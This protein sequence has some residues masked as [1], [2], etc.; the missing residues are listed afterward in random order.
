MQ[1]RRTQKDEDA[2]KAFISTISETDLGCFVEQV[3]MI[4]A[5]LQVHHDVQ[6]GRVVR[7]PARVQALE[8]PGQDVAI[9][10]PLHRGQVDANN[11][12][13]LRDE[14]LRSRT[15]MS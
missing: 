4:A 9:E 1:Q 11:E 6:Q 12:L 14:T 2:A 5:F 3:R 15:P 10:L 8:V 13:A 7:A